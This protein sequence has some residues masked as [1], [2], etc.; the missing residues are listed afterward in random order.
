MI[1][2]II[3]EHHRPHVLLRL[4]LPRWG[5]DR[6]LLFRLDTGADMTVLHPHDATAAGIPF[7]QLDRATLYPATGV[8]GPV[9]YFQEPALLSFDDHDGTTT[10]LYP[11]DLRIAN[12]PT[13]GANQTLWNLP[14]LLGLDIINQWQ[15]FYDPVNGQLEFVVRK[16]LAIAADG[17]ATPLG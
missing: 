8:G 16:G 13:P 17:I 14:S 10:Y 1:R 12:L 11:I 5:V 4:Q 9:P 7:A 6:Y 15:T 2:G 3:G